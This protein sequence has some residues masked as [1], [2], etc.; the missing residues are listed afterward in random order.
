MALAR[1]PIWGLLA[2][3][4]FGALAELRGLAEET[5]GI[6]EGKIF[7]G[8]SGKLGSLS[9]ERE[10]LIFKNGTLH[11]TSCDPYGFGDGPYTAIPSADGTRFEAVTASRTHGLI[12]WSG[13]VKGT[14]L[15][16]RFIWH[17]PRKWYRPWKSS[18]EYWVK[19]AQR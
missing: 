19:A 18:A 16:G 10:E 5:P 7:V 4:L 9:G 12:E 8:Q 15:T 17:K 11:S 2:V 6:L 3:M 14:E 1:L 13:V